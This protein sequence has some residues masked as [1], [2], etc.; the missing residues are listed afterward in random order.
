MRMSKTTICLALLF[1]ALLGFRWIVIEKYNAV[2]L[3]NKTPTVIP[4][5]KNTQLVIQKK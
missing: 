2:D 1:I 4:E 3:P 5:E